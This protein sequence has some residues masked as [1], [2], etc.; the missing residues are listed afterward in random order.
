M[1]PPPSQ[2]IQPALAHSA[3]TALSHTSLTPCNKST[4][5][6]IEA[7]AEQPDSAVAKLTAENLRKIGKP[8]IHSLESVSLAGDPTTNLLTSKK[9]AHALP[10]NWEMAVRSNLRFHIQDKEIRKYRMRRRLEQ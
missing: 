2:G 1:G 6:S 3:S 7:T 5:F 10:T 8:S 9:H 4:R